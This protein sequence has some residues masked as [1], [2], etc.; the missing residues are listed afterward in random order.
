MK[1]STSLKIILFLPKYSS[2]SGRP[3]IPLKNSP[4]QKKYKKKRTKGNSSGGP[5]WRVVAK[6]SLFFLA[7]L[8]DLVKE[9][10]IWLNPYTYFLGF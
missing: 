1:I 7:K 5:T 2:D 9:I 3:K 4:P 8:I 6:P 10:S